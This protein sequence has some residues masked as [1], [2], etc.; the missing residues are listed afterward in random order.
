MSAR[1]GPAGRAAFSNFGSW[2]DACAIGVDVV[3]TFFT[4]FDDRRP[5]D[6]LVDEYRGWARWSGTSFSGPKVAAAVAQELYLHGGTA[7]EAW[8]RLSP[9]T[10]L[11]LPDLGVVVNI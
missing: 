9:P 3:S 10:A 7:R 1:I 11:R 2:V 8:K 5:D 4:D 6:R